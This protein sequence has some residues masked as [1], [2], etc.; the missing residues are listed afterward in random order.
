MT[1]SPHYPNFLIAA[2]TAATLIC[3]GLADMYLPVGSKEAH[4]AQVLSK[5]GPR[6]AVAYLEATADGVLTRRDMQKI[7][8]AS[9]TDLDQPGALLKPAQ[10]KQ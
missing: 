6:G 8:D 3:I 4:A 2:V 7:R 5:T 9:G 1:S 10:R